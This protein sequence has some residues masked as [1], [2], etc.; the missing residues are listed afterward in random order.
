[1][2]VAALASTMAVTKKVL[3]CST[4]VGMENIFQECQNR[5]LW[6]SIFHL[7]PNSRKL[8]RLPAAGVANAKRAGGNLD[9]SSVQ[10]N[11]QPDGIM[12]SAEKFS[13]NRFNLA[14]HCA[15]HEFNRSYPPGVGTGIRAGVVVTLQSNEMLCKTEIAASSS[16]ISRRLPTRNQNVVDSLVIQGSA[17]FFQCVSATTTTWPASAASPKSTVAK[18]LLEETS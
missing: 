4:M 8:S 13:P 18:P 16:L 10:L 5:D 2:P 3:D 11:I 17:I 15:S 9:S 12:C 14:A 1:M 7:F 6:K